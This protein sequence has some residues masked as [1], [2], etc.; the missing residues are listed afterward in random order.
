MKIERLYAIMVYLLNHGK[1]PASELADYFEVSLRTI[2]R[3]MESL[4]LAG[5]PI[6]ST[7]GVTGGYEI[8]DR[9]RLDKGFVTYDEYSYILTAL[10]GLVSAT[11]DLKAKHILEK[12]AHASASNTQGIILDFSVLQ[13]GDQSILQQLQ[14]AV[15]RKQAV[16]FTYTNN[17]NET[18]THCV[19]PIAVLYRWYA[20]YLL[21]YSRARKDYRTY[22]IVRMSALNLT[23]EPF[24]IQHESADIILKKID[25]TD[26]RQYTEIFVKSKESA[27]ARIREYLKGTIVEEY[28]NG[29][30]LI[31]AT[32]VENEQLWIGTLL[33]LGNLA[34]VLAPEKIRKRLLDA[35]KNIVFLYEKL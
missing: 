29:D 30:A 26:S 20:W 35:A 2:Q 18:R 34:E 19:E 33:S 14:T 4:C 5:I 28:E 24:V 17:D 10:R 25:K 6:C 3:D 9:F 23:E 32:I 12:V 11:Q 7:T 1:T 16:C 13:E 27:K 15:T 21:A 31:E 22:K 8:S